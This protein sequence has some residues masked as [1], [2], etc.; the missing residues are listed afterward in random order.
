LALQKAEERDPDAG[1]MANPGH[2]TQ[3]KI[4]LTIRKKKQK[5]K[6]ICFLVEETLT[7]RERFFAT[8]FS[9][10]SFSFSVL[11]A[12]RQVTVTAATII[13]TIKKI[14]ALTLVGTLDV[15]Y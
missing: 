6:T 3:R 15:F 2:F 12:L 10:R 5:K 4:Q 1:R 11:L 14:Y 13:T 8:L 9:A 7:S